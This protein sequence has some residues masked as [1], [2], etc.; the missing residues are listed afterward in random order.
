MDKVKEF[1]YFFDPLAKITLLNNIDNID[2][3]QTYSIK[4]Q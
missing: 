3:P 2:T 4:N 1:F